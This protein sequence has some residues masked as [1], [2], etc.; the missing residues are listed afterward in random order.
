MCRQHPLCWED[1]ALR[2]AVER[3]AR[4]VLCVASRRT[5]RCFWP[6]R[7]RK[8]VETFSSGSRRRPSHTPT[9]SLRGCRSK[10]SHRLYKEVVAL[11]TP[12]QLSPPSAFSAPGKKMG[13]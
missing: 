8:Q 11:I 3:S 6:R 9:L 12:G 4:L 10:Y 13:K 2:V 1:T 5:C 7:E